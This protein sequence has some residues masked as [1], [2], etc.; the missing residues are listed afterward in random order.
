MRRTL[1]REENAGIDRSEWVVL[2]RATA[3]LGP[4]VR[5]PHWHPL[6]TTRMRAWSDDFSGLLSILQW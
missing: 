3:D 5:D 1:S 2:A 4:L 6:P